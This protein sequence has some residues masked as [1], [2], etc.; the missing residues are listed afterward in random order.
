MYFTRRFDGGLGV[1]VSE[2]KR[3]VEI[4]IAIGRSDFPIY[5]SDIN[6]L[7]IK[8]MWTEIENIIDRFKQE[9]P[10]NDSVVAE[11]IFKDI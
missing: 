3:L 7:Y 10:A 9:F 2:E 5:R 4:F 8:E 1:I 11:T 6:V